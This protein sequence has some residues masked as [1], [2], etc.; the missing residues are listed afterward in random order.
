MPIRHRTTLNRLWL[1]VPVAGRRWRRLATRFLRFGPYD[2]RLGA[3]LWDV[4]CYVDDQRGI[5]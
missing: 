2:S 1:A 3:Y 4:G 5:A